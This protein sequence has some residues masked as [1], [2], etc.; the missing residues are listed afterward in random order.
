MA[1]GEEVYAG[2]HF[3]AAG[4]VEAYHV[5]KW[6]GTSWSSIGIG[7]GG[8]PGAHVNALAKMGDYL[9]VAGYFT[10]VGDAEVYELPANSIAR[11]NLITERWEILG[12]GIEYLQGIPGVV[13]DLEVYGDMIY[14]GGRFYLADESF[15]ENIAAL[16]DNKWTGVEGVEDSGIEGEVYVIK[17][18]NDEVYIGGFLQLERNGNSYGILKWQKEE[19][20]QVGYRL[21]ADDNYV[22]VNDIEAFEN[23]IFAGGIFATGDIASVGLANYVLEDPAPEPQPTST[24][25]E[26]TPIAFKLEQ[27]YP[28]PFN[29]VTNISYSIVAKFPVT[30][31]V[32]D[33]LGRLVSTLVDEVKGPGNYRIT[34][35]GRNLS[36]G[37]YLY[38]MRTN[39]TTET[40][41]LILLK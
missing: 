12:K 28:N 29:P 8:V 18:I 10:V 27:N 14:V 17:V 25:G 38:Q 23:G 19:W 2:G 30:I 34:F 22:I 24:E 13:Y 3:G 9:Y 35:D 7:V 21:L 6:D 40:R 5:A 31:Q 39:K 36:S 41:K 26:G 15:H 32:F 37:I 20:Q 1:D 4:S 16:K 33:S 11:F